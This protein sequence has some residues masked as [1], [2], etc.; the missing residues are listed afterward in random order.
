I[1][2][3][4]SSVSVCVPSLQFEEPVR[5]IALLVPFAHGLPMRSPHAHAQASA[6][7]RRFSR[8]LLGFENPGG[9][10]VAGPASTP[11]SLAATASTLNDVHPSGNVGPLSAFPSALVPV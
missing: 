1:W 5:N 11:P 10:E 7:E 6:D 2:H 4:P 3:C 8:I 9:H